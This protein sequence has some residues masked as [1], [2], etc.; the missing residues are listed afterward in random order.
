MLALI[1]LR[2]QSGHEAINI[3]TGRG[4]TVKEMV[5]EFE[6]TSSCSIQRRILEWRPG[7]LP[8]F[9]ANSDLARERLG[10]RA[11]LGLTEMC[12]DTWTWQQ[13]NPNGFKRYEDS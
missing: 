5:D 10:W 8:S 6:V 9:F 1:S 11:E 3:G 4:V 13:K 12:Q 2:K 7:D